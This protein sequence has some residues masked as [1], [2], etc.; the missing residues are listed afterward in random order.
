MLLVADRW[1]EFRRATQLDLERL[2]TEAHSELEEWVRTTFSV[3]SNLPQS[4]S[5][6]FR[7]SSLYEVLDIIDRLSAAMNESL[8][9]DAGD[10]FQHEIRFEIKNDVRRGF[11]PTPYHLADFM[12]AL[13]VSHGELPIRV[14]DLAAGT[15][16]LLAAALRYAPNAELIGYEFNPNVAEVGIANLL[17]HYPTYFPLRV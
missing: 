13:A 11:Y 14:V 2:L 6:Q 8:W 4:P 3:H 16:G 5:R 17:L 15:G 12:A 9:H 7:G 10:F 1:E